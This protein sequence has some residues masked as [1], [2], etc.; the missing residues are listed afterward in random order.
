M[1]WKLDVYTDS[2]LE[3]WS[4]FHILWLWCILVGVSLL[5]QH[6]AVHNFEVKCEWCMVYK[7]YK[8]T[9]RKMWWLWCTFCIRTPSPSSQ[10]HYKHLQTFCVVYS[11]F[12]SCC[13]KLGLVIKWC[14]KI[15][16]VYHLNVKYGTAAN[17]QKHRSEKQSYNELIVTLEELQRFTALFSFEFNNKEIL[18]F[19]DRICQKITFNHILHEC[20]R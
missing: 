11:L 13:L 6:K 9:K 18:L 19:F 4:L 17:L 7:N 3:S 20:G 15:P 12:E 1:L 8:K 10:L 2:A 16:S 5:C 14:F